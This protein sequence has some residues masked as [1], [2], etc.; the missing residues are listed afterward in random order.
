[1][2]LPP[3]YKGFIVHYKLHA[4]LYLKAP[5]YCVLNLNFHKIYNGKNKM[6]MKIRCGSR[7]CNFLSNTSL[8]NAFA[9]SDLFLTPLLQKNSD[10]INPNEENKTNEHY[11]NIVN[12]SGQM[13]IW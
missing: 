7:I 13:M 9:K 1:M 10:N 5:K 6:L 12:A 4:Y 8:L 2:T 3:R 11:F